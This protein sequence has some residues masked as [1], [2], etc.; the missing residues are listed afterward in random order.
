MGY[1]G[2]RQVI[3]G[4]FIGILIVGCMQTQVS[5]P[6]SSP[7]ELPAIT[8]IV[9]TRVHSPAATSIEL[10]VVTTIQPIATPTADYQIAAETDSYV[11]PTPIPVLTQPVCYETNNGGI[12]C[13]GRVDNGYH[14][15]LV[16]VVVLVEVYRADGTLLESR[17]VAI[18][19]R[20]IPVGESAPYRIYIPADDAYIP[21][22]DFGTVSVSLLQ[23]ERA[24]QTDEYFAAL[25]IDNQQVE[26]NDGR[27]IA[28]ADL[29]NPG[30][31][32]VHLVRIVVT[33][34]GDDE[35]VVGYRIIETGMIPAGEIYSARIEITPMIDSLL[36]HHTLYIEAEK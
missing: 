3:L 4:L 1:W 14:Y 21:A 36:L 29:Y 31:E 27:Y 7:T 22:D 18:E 20:L 30:P 2:W 8:L 34:Y 16:Q 6:N 23:A 15:P 25:I 28:S 33:L 10:P 5:L 35:Q 17:E 24:E 12:L 9:R 13:L 19:Q 11:V 32:D 26:T